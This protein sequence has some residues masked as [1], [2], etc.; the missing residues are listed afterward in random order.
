ME[1]TNITQGFNQ[2][3]S[4]PRDKHLGT[5]EVE[6]PFLT[7]MAGIRR[8]CHYACRERSEKSKKFFI[9]KSNQGNDF[10]SYNFLF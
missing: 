10:Y 2:N 6:K 8:K 1:F 5:A 7:K 9:P 3:H 4:N